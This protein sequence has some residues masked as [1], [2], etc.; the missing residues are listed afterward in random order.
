MFLE[1]SAVMKTAFVGFSLYVIV[2]GIFLA[3]NVVSFVGDSLDF[4]LDH[5]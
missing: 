3:C 2:A 1:G 4:V 5:V